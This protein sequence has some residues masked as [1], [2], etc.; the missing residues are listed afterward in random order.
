MSSSLQDATVKKF[1]ES[2]SKPRKGET[3]NKLSLEEDA[4][5]IA[6][7]GDMVCDDAEEEA[8]DPFVGSIGATKQILKTRV[9]PLVL[10][11]IV[12][13]MPTEVMN[14]RPGLQEVQLHLF[15]KDI[16]EAWLEYDAASVSCQ[17]R[18]A[19]HR[20][21]DHCFGDNENQ[22]YQEIP[23][24]LLL[25]LT[26]A[27]TG[28][29][30]DAACKSMTSVV[31]KLKEQL[32]STPTQG[33]E[34]EDVIRLRP[35]AAEKT[36]PPRS[37]RMERCGNVD[38]I[39]VDDIVDCLVS[40]NLEGM[41]DDRRADCADFLNYFF[42]IN[43]PDG[44]PK[45]QQQ[46]EEER[47]VFLDFV[48][49]HMA[50]RT[51]EHSV[52]YLRQC[53]KTRFWSLKEAVTANLEDL[54]V[55]AAQRVLSEEWRCSCQ[56]AVCKKR[57]QGKA[58]LE[59]LNGSYTTTTFHRAVRAL[60]L[61]RHDATNIFEK[62][63]GGPSLCE[64]FRCLKD[65]V[66][67]CLIRIEKHKD[68]GATH[69]MVLDI[70]ESFQ[71]FPM[72][73]NKSHIDCC[74][75]ILGAIRVFIR[76]LVGQREHDP[77]Q[78][79]RVTNRVEELIFTPKAPQEHFVS[80]IPLMLL[81]NIWPKIYKLF[82][83][84][85]AAAVSSEE[86]SRIVSNLDRVSLF[87]VLLYKRCGA[88]FEDFANVEAM[89]KTF[90]EKLDCVIYDRFRKCSQSKS[91]ADL[92]KLAKKYYFFLSTSEID[93]W[94]NHRAQD[95]LQQIFEKNHS[96]FFLPPYQ[97]GFRYADLSRRIGPGGVALM[98]VPHT[99]CRLPAPGCIRQFPLSLRIFERCH[100]DYFSLLPMCYQITG[101]ELTS[102]VRK[103]NSFHLSCWFAGDLQKI[104]TLQMRHQLFPSRH[105]IV[106]GF[107]QLGSLFKSPKNELLYLIGQVE[108]KQ[109]KRVLESIS[110]HQEI[111]QTSGWWDETTAFL[112]RAKLDLSIEE[113]V[114]AVIFEEHGYV[115]VLEDGM[116]LLPKQR[117]Q[118]ERLAAELHNFLKHLQEKNIVIFQEKLCG[119]K[120]L[121]Y[122]L[123]GSTFSPCYKHGV[124]MFSDWHGDDIKKLET[125]IKDA[126]KDR[127]IQASL[128]F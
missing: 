61:L 10:E 101:E 8:T 74:C 32:K 122:K 39:S 21:L 126:N 105:V 90:T 29:R 37:S 84:R 11:M 100:F 67:G 70:L 34:T 93:C 20:L 50:L 109:H 55:E 75:E 65:F 59:F 91:R 7:D 36:A 106:D 24:F 98:C 85:V 53:L 41:T 92:G 120:K 4:D 25:P 94:N 5:A 112:K 87:R 99:Y 77:R 113:K 22:L 12:K 116:L 76:I 63:K 110:R 49:Q 80:R 73:T 9:W 26:V 35:A 33:M 81:G 66:Q 102:V 64:D 56:A 6:E 51:P 58:I 3:N 13:G 123:R 121:L 62:W 125:Y 30:V 108:E 71:E 114:N 72:L 57:P 97:G 82:H 28:R 69:A 47:Y 18:N 1:L 2:F 88:P 118:Q 52:Y 46:Y 95:V 124:I 43:L 115:P 128:S 16:H 86:L 96:T 23:L 19:L 89:L 44:T 103:L 68:E 83:E 38:T 42:D 111:E 45:S 17:A 54:A 119:Q 31:R 40:R 48:A 79:E 14:R 117:F 78:L 27:M 127:V 60:Y 107:P 15:S 104:H